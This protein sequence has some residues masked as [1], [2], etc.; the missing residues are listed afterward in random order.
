MNFSFVVFDTG[1][2]GHTLQLLPF[3]PAVEK[4][5]KR[6]L[7]FKNQVGPI[8]TQVISFPRL[9]RKKIKESLQ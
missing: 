3:P 5:L 6:I 9:E 7:R 2:T 4:G 1:R 8:L